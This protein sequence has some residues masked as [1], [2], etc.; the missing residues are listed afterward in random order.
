MQRL[1]FD[2]KVVRSDD[3]YTES[4]RLEPVSICVCACFRLLPWGSSCCQLFCLSLIQHIFWSHPF[5]GTEA[6]YAF[7]LLSLYQVRVG[8]GWWFRYKGMP[9][10]SPV[11]K[12]AWDSSMPASLSTYNSVYSVGSVNRSSYKE[13]LI[14]TQQHLK[15]LLC[16][17][18]QKNTH[19][20]THIYT[21]TQ[22]TLAGVAYIIT[23]W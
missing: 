12:H 3:Q 15:I 8:R 23:L 9:S 2:K 5:S 22:P 11:H 14:N 18:H 20:H 1:L 4:V 7:E 19:T 17:W 13:L 10:L 21:D 16:L 6:H